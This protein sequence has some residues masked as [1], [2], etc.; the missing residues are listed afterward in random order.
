MRQMLVYAGSVIV[1][2]VAVSSFWTAFRVRVLSVPSD[3]S[4]RSEWS[5]IAAARYLDYREEWWQKWPAVQREQGTFCISCHTVLPYAFVRPALRQQLGEIELTSAEKKML[6]SITMRVNGWPQ[7]SPYY[8]DATDAA[9]SRSTEAVLN[10]VILAAY[11]AEQGQL[12]IPSR[13]AFDEA[14]ALQLTKGENA[15]GWQWLNFHEAPWESDES[16][17]QGAAMMAIAA[18]M[19]PE[20]NSSNPVVRDHLQ[21][22]REFLL[23]HYAVQP[24]MSQLYVVW[25][26]AEMPELL[27]DTQR[28]ELI[29]NIASIQQSDGGWSLPSLDRQANLKPAVLDLFKRTNRVG[30]SDGCA[31]GLAV[32]ALEKAGITS[33][34]RVLQRGLAW[35]KTH[36]SQQGSWW[37]SSM[38]GFPDP[39]SDRGH[40]MSD[41]ATGYAV[42]A[43][44]SAGSQSIRPSPVHNGDT[45]GIPMHVSSL[46]R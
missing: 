7:M 24:P 4:Y 26:S 15:G 31:T 21:H 6:S 2:G 25:A 46:P 3:G 32:L 37:A 13:R 12:S 1:L 23:R 5:P 39:A 29:K 17:Y 28:S 19:T 34:D 16:A 8:N 30:G 35:L 33:Q 9:P 18:G 22:L 27:D 41:A 40:F 10:A 44:E 45:A 43:L 38:N 14:W 42:L 11:S 20:R 36:Q